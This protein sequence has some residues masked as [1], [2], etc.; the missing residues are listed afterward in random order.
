MND[1]NGN[2]AWS[3]CSNVAF[4]LWRT[5]LIALLSGCAGAPVGWGGSY[6]VLLKSEKAITIEY[7]ELVSS[8][9]E[10]GVVAQAHCKSHGKVAVPAGET[11]TRV[12]GLI[13]TH[14]FRCE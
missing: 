8:Y 2:R 12:S 9:K 14:T 5:S 3:R 4:W 7:D 10:V 13:K 11:T 6:E 1:S